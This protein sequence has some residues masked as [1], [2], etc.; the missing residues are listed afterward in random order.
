ME[1][2]IYEALKWASSYLIEHGRDVNAGE[3]VMKHVLKTSRSDLLARLHDELK[4]GQM[5]AFQ[6][7]VMDHA[8]GVPVQHL[9][10]TED[11]YGRSFIVNGDVLIPRPETEELVYHALQ[12]IKTMTNPI[13]AD[14]GTGSG[15]I[16]VTMKAERPDADVYAVDLSAE[17]IKTA[18]QNAEVL[19]AEITFLQG[20]LAAPLMERE[21]IVD[22]LLSN[23]P[24]IPVNERE[25]LSTVVVD[26]EPHMALFGG[27]DGLD[28]YRKLAEQLPFVMKKGGLVGVETGAGQTKDVAAMFQASFPN[29]ETE[30]VYDINGKDRMVF[31][32]V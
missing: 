7:M 15:A 8:K 5:A 4:S 9:I 2:K 10:G 11:F 25:T 23:P 32:Y 3:L 30:I 20:D 24:Y 17:A 22:I 29:R 12:K 26:Y 1:Q 6:Q 28:L 31:L 19:G 21:L 13:I 16:A 27:K 18:A 14:I